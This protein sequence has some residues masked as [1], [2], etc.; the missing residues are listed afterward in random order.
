MKKCILPLLLGGL[1]ISCATTE[2]YP[3]KESSLT[4][5]ITGRVVDHHKNPVKGVKV[6][7]T[8]LR[9]VL[10]NDKGEFVLSGPAP[11]TDSLTVNFSAAEFRKTSRVY[12]AATRVTG[13]GTTVIV[14]TRV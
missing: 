3:P 11:R 1:L 4:V 9:M 7:A 2:K 12:K 6:E 13:N 14:W 8:G 10:T 5:S